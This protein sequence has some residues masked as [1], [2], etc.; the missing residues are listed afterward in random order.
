MMMKK[1]KEIRDLLEK[2]RAQNAFE[3]IKE[4][5]GER[6]DGRNRRPDFTIP[7]EIV[8][9]AKAGIQIADYLHEKTGL[10]LRVFLFSHDT[11]FS[12]SPPLFFHC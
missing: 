11:L 2:K 12:P 1:S 10:L 7:Q 5:R 6:Q 8:I 4:N 3:I 9:P